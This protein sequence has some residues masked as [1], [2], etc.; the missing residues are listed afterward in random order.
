[1]E[2]YKL[3]F[4]PNEDVAGLAYLLN[5]LISQNTLR[6]WQ[7][8]VSSKNDRAEYW[9]KRLI[10][11]FPWSSSKLHLENPARQEFRDY[12]YRAIHGTWTCIA[13]IKSGVRTL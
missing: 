11:A 4:I 2:M 13:Y 8:T 9:A 10:V 5:L 7:G 6:T 1:L 3:Y 12:L